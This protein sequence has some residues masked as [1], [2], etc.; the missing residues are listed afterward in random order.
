[1]GL[2]NGKRQY[3]IKL[4]TNIEFMAGGNSERR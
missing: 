3:N 1:M 4:F 2:I